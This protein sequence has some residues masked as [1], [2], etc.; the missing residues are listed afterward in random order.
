MRP[1]RLM[2]CFEGLC[3]SKATSWTVM[4]IGCTLETMCPLLVQWYISAAL[5]RYKGKHCVAVGTDA[6]VVHYAYF[7]QER[8]LLRNAPGLLNEYARCV[9]IQEIFH[10]SSCRMQTFLNPWP[11]NGEQLLL[12]CLPSISV[13]PQGLAKFAQHELHTSRATPAMMC[14]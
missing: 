2:L 11:C 3:V 12:H 1:Q 13:A 6:L 14:D 5:P 10:S 8:D 7:T 9:I 4:K